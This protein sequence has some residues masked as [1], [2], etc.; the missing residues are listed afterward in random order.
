MNPKHCT[1]EMEVVNGEYVC[2]ICDHTENAFL[3][4][5]PFTAEQWLHVCDHIALPVPLHTAELNRAWIYMREYGVF[6]CDF[7]A[8]TIAMAYLHAYLDLGLDYM[9]VDFDEHSEAFL[10]R[11][12][13]AFLS[14]AMIGG[15]VKAGYKGSLN[16]TE[17][18]LF[19]KI[20]NIRYMFGERD[21]T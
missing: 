15:G 12:G 7:G 16:R 3:P 8:H 13:R 9:D 17:V 11:E 5:T 10:A 2:S 1:K 4:P 19:N 20:S 6:Y 14:G 21:D 18:R